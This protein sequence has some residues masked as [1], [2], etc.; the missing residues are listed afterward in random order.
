VGRYALINRFPLPTRHVSAPIVDPEV[1]ARY[2]DLGDDFEDLDTVV[3][4][5]FEESDLEAL[6]NQNAYRAEQVLVILGSGLVS[7]LGAAEAAFAG[8]RWWGVAVAV[9]GVLVAGGSQYAKERDSLNKFL[10]ARVRAERLRGEY[11][12]FLA[13]IKPYDGDDRV[14]ALRRAVARIRRGQEPR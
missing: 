2:S 3:A 1:R 10:S 5:P 12:W 4:E 6:Q 8:Q 11:F 13:R 14:P 7:V 9:A